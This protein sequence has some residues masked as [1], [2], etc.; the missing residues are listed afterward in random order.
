MVIEKFKYNQ[1]YFVWLS[2]KMVSFKDHTLQKHSLAERAIF[3][4]YLKMLI[5]SSYAMDIGSVP[6]C[7]TLGIS[8]GI[9]RFPL[10]SK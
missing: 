9:C 7:V 2:G 4:K 1:I 3:N 10:Y 6:S 8:L 5:T